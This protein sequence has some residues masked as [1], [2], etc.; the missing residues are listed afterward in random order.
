LSHAKERTEKI[1]LNCQEALHGRFC[2]NCGQ[3]NREPKESV[4][5]LITHFFYDI[6]HFDGKFFST[7]KYLALKPGFLPKEYIMGRRASYLNP[8]RM[9][10][11]TSAFFFI[12]FFSIF[13]T[14]NIGINRNT[15]FQYGKDSAVYKRQDSISKENLKKL[16]LK[17]VGTKEDSAEILEAFERAP[18]SMARKTV[19]K[20]PVK[21]STTL[22]DY[23]TIQQYDSIQ[24]TLPREKRDGWFE[25][26]MQKRKIHLKKTYG[27][28]DTAMM[29]DWVNSFV[30]QFPKLLFVSLPLFALILQLLYIRRR[31]FF[32]V[33]HGIFSIYL[34]IF[35]FVVLLLS[36]GLSYL[37]DIT[38][39]GAINWLQLPLWLY[40]VYYNYKS[41]R[42][43]YGQGTG[44]T[45]VKF[46]LLNI[47]ASISILILFILFFAI[48]AFQL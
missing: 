1:C 19:A 34:Y 23:K 36:F 8:I 29:K 11:F 20:Q 25:R 13:N 38:G 4:W 39:W 26:L 40:V 32:Y 18:D 48:T 24:N 47:L 31:K 9:Y 22:G 12:I 21:F 44:K 43:F 5:G 46:I 7:L 15:N 30:H 28:N 37:A 45:L 33:S 27:D 6:T 16:A 17:Y 41:M 35:G 14:N 42:V 10:V 3:E 2:H